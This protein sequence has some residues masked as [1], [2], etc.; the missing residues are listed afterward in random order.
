VPS[1]VR[2][3]K[4]K[5]FLLLW[6]VRYNTAVFIKG[7]SVMA[8]SWGNES[9]GGG[10]GVSCFQDIHSLPQSSESFLSRG[11]VLSA[12]DLSLSG[13]KASVAWSAPNWLSTLCQILDLRFRNLNGMQEANSYRLKTTSVVQADAIQQQETKPPVETQGQAVVAYLSTPIEFM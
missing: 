12:K 8:Q 9:V 11:Q 13:L 10:L 4:E 5:C 3:H 7:L 2:R 6:S 1:W